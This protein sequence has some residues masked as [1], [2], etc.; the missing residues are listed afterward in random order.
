MMYYVRTSDNVEIA[1]YDLNPCAC[2]TIV[3]VH[4]WP[5]SHKIFEY[6]AEL[7]IKCGYRVILLDL[8]GFGN[9]DAPACG[10][11][12]SRMADDIY[13]VVNNLRL[14]NFILV[15]FSMGGGIVVR[16]MGRYG[17]YQ[18]R[19]LVLL[20]AAAPLYT[21]RPDYPYGRTKEFVDGLIEQAC[22]D[23]PK[24]CADFGNMLFAC[25]HSQQVR[26]WFRQISYDASGIGTVQTAIAL[27][28]E[29][30]R[31]DMAKICVPTGIFH[32]K[33][34]QIVPYELAL[35]QHEGIRNS[36]LFPFEYSGHGIFYDELQCFNK[37]F[38][39]F[40]QEK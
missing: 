8:R 16:Y 24:M 19:K 2:N 17:G 34:D 7:L 40:I 6:Q 18:V 22:N 32:G 9:S 3:M 25:P 28:D 10:Y 21:R 14:K 4:G 38:L 11:G 20:G 36:K 23:R 39:E 27:R 37:T 35:V 31:A 15:G 30:C 5:L 12:Y 33:Q 13:T 29:D 1:V 26:D